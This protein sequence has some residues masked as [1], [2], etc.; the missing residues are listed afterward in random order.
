[1][2]LGILRRLSYLQAEPAW[3]PEHSGSW[4]AT[5]HPALQSASLNM[6]VFSVCGYKEAPTQTVS[7][8]S[9]KKSSDDCGI[10]SRFVR[11]QSGR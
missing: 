1:M 5:L 4:Q 11:Y 10:A 2:R 8:E 3:H 7:K 6:R 9:T